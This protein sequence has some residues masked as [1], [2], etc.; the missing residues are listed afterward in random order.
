MVVGRTYHPVWDPA[1]C[2]SCSA[3][4]RACPVWFHQEP[5]DEPDSLRM[6]VARGYSFPD[7]PG[8]HPVPPC[9]ATCLLHQDV[10]G[11]LSAIARG[12]LA[13]AREIILESN[14]LPGVLSRVCNR[15]CMS[16]CVRGALDGAVD[17]RRLKGIAFG[18][19][20]PPTGKRQARRGDEQVA[21]VGSG[22]AGLAAAALLAR[23]GVR[24]LVLERDDEP[25]GML[26]YAIPDF[27]LPRAAL[28]AD[29]GR[30]L[31]AGVVLE[32]G[33]D[34][35]LP[36]ELDLLFSSGVGAVILA[37][38]AGCGRISFGVPGSPVPE[39]EGLVD[40]V[41]FMRGVATGRIGTIDGPV[42]VQ[43]EG[44]AALAAARAAGR[45][46][47]SPVLLVV[48]RT[49]AL[50]AL[51]TGT[52]ALAEAEG[53]EVLE[54]AAVTEVRRNRS[55]LAVS[56]ARC[57]QIPAGGGRVVPRAGDRLS[58][59]EASLCVCAGRRDAQHEALARIGGA[60]LTPIGTLAVDAGTLGVGPSGLFA[61]GDVVSG[62]KTVVEAVASGAKA[63]RSVLRWLGGGG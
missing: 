27:D 35:D 11:Y 40:A 23:A 43:G 42:V 4:R 48:P 30:I 37:T 19:A 46:G 56:L 45:L 38:G 7:V 9:V 62:P 63:A 54:A 6:R 61:A 53:V 31:D 20:P 57:D 32:T 41:S 58:T 12:D 36:R 55:L 1:S 47:G 17:I 5:G 28:D 24:T 59:L 50:A 10:P 39:V 18:E 14:P 13:R 25:G 26:R 60:S 44:P 29:I 3:C 2:L 33:V 34:V 22:P 21:V 15:S 8:T 51:D 52:L 16:V 49:R